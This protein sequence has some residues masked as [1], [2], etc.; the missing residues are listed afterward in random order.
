ME[1][2]GKNKEKKLAITTVATL[3]GVL[4]FIIIIDPQLERHKVLANQ[5][6][7]QQINLAKMKS[8]LLVKD[9]IEKEYAEIEPLVSSSRTDQQE[10]SLFTR[11]LNDLYSPL[12]VKIGS[13]KI[14]PLV[15]NEFCRRL[16]IKIEMS[17]DIKDILKFIRAIEACRNPLKIERLTL[18]VKEIVDQVQV[19][20]LISKVI[21]SQK[22]I[23]LKAGE[24][25]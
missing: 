18:D 12:Q 2:S 25:K 17:G 9:R 21:A 6:Y 7:Q 22:K 3:A 24:N 4:I 19:S 8:D 20:F 13:V 1:P 14:F 10:I 11:E 15:Q 23:A 16:S 5:I